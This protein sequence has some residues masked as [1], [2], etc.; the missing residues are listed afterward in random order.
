MKY[1]TVLIAVA[2]AGMGC[3]GAGETVLQDFGIRD[4]P[5]G[6]VS[7]SDLVFERLDGIGATELKRLNS[8]SRQGEVK[9][10]D[11][12]GLHGMYYKEVKVY[13]KFFPLDARATGRSGNRSDRGYAGTIDYAYEIYQGPRRATRTEAAAEVANIPTGDRGRETFRYRFSSGGTW[14]GARG[15]SVR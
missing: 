1:V 2:L 7:G 8:R 10:E 5:E 11:D 12:A 4:R 9:F 3:G 14:N 13:E 6:Y 15:E